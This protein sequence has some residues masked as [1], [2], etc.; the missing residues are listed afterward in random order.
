MLRK[1]FDDGKMEAISEGLCLP[2][3]N[4]T[5]APSLRTPESPESTPAMRQVMRSSNTLVPT[6]KGDA[7]LRVGHVGVSHFEILVDK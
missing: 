7:Q 5:S 1:P 2:T 6:R 4:R 3:N